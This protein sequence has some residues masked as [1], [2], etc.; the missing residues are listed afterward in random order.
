VPGV[1]LTQISVGAVSRI[2]GVNAQ[3]EINRYVFNNG[4]SGWRRIEGSLID[5]SVGAD[6]VV[7]GV[8]RNSTVYV[9]VG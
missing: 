2:W 7:Y 1:S 3:A 8:A 4:A 6:G 5:V 9:Y